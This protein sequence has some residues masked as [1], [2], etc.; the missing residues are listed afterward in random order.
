ML[1]ILVSF[2][3][4]LFLGAMLVLGSVQRWKGAIDEKKQIGFFFQY[5][6]CIGCFLSAKLQ[7]QILSIQ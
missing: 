2:W 1:G 4:G 6:L 7:A 5:K 3:D